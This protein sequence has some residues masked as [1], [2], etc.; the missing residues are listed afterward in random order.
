M[1]VTVKRKRIEWLDSLRAVAALLVV[2]QHFYYDR[3]FVSRTQTDYLQPAYEIFRT[4]NFGKMG[5]VIFFFISGYIIPRSLLLT[6]RQK[7]IKSF[8]IAR[9]F[10]LYPAYWL[11][12]LTVAVLTSQLWTKTFFINLTMIQQMLGSK[13]LIDVYWT[14]QIELIFYV[15]CGFLFYKNLLNKASTA[16]IMLMLSLAGA[17]IAAAARAITHRSLP[18]AIPLSLAVMFLGTSYYW[19]TNNRLSMSTKKFTTLFAIFALMLLP[20]CLL[21]YSRETGFSERWYGYYCSYM[22]AISLFLFSSTRLQ[23]NN[24]VCVYLGTISYSIYLFHPLCWVH[25]FAGDLANGAASLLTTI[26]VASMSYYLI[27]KPA[28]KLGNYV[29]T[30]LE[31]KNKNIHPAIA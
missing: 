2:F 11:S 17:L 25:P 30:K 12:V 5:V 3:F 16:S 13:N 20:I 28:Q 22:S 31:I 8:F 1:E 15:I 19:H 7:P 10:R 27:E 4:I 23:L 21:A 24:R 14:L 9:F 6:K 18:V 29:R 26:C